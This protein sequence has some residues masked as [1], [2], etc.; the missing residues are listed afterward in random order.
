MASSRR[1][2][3][4]SKRKP[5]GS[6]KA[7]P[8]PTVDFSMSIS[9]VS[10]EPTPI[11]ESSLSSSYQ[12]H[13]LRRHH[14][15]R[16]SRHHG[17]S[18]RGGLR[19]DSP[20]TPRRPV[21][22]VPELF[23]TF[24]HV[25]LAVDVPVS[26]AAA[27][28]AAQASSGQLSRESLAA[29]QLPTIAN[30]I[31]GIGAALTA[32]KTF[33]RRQ[34]LKNVTGAFTP[35]SMTLLLGRSGSGKSVL[36][37]LLGGRLNVTSKS[38]T[39]DGEVSYNG[40]SRDELKA[41][42]PQCVSFVPQQDTHLPVMTVKETLDFAFE[43]CA[44]NPDAKPVGAVYK[45][46]ASEYPLAL[47]AT[48]LGGE[49]DPVTVTRELGLTRCQGTIVGDERIR[50]VS[51]GEKKRVTTGEMAFGPHAVSLM[52]EITT[53]LD[54]SAAFDIVNAQRRLARQQRQTVVISLQ[55]PAPEVLALFDNVLLLA[56]GEVLYH[57]PR[58]HVQTYFEALGF[59]CPPGRDLADF[60]CDLASPQQIQYEKSHAPMPGRRR[61]PRSANEFADLWIMSPMYE[62][63]VEEL[64]HLDND[65]EAYSQTHSRN[66][67]RGLFFDQEALLRVPA[68]RQSYLRSTWTVVKR[69]MRLFARNKVF[70][71][72]RLLLDLLVGLMVGS[73]Y[74]GIDLADSQV[75]LGVIFSCALFLGLGQS[76]T[77]AP[78]FDAREVFYKHRGANFYRT[79]SYVLATCLSQIP[80]AITE[81]LVFGSL[82]YWMGGFIA[83]A[84][85]FVVF[86]LYML[87]TVLVFVG[88][89]FFLSTACST[90]HVA[91]PASTLALLFFILFAGFAVSREQLP[92][93][94][95]WIY[96]SNPLA[97]TTRGVMVSQYRS[98][99]LDVCEYGGIDYC[100][101][102]GGQTLG[103]YSLGLYDVPDDPKWVV[104]GIVFLASM[105]VVSMF[106]SF[107]MLE[108]HCH[109]SSS[110]LPPSLP[111]SF[112]NTAI[113]TPRQPKESYAMLSTPHGDADELL[114]SDI[115]GFPGDRNGIAVL[116]GDDDINESF[117]AS[118]GLRTNTEEIM[119][120][121][122]PRWD[123]PPV[124]LAFQD[125]RYS[126]TV[127]ADAVADPAGAP[128]RPV[129]VDSRDNAGKTKET[130]TRELLKGVTG[131]AVPGTMTALMG[132]TGA[133]KTT[134]MDVL[135]GRKS[136]K[137]GSNKKKKNGAPTLRGRVLLNG[138]DATELAVR[139]CTGYCEQ[140]DVHSDA[141][142]FREAL[143]FS[144]YLRQ[145]DR[146]APERVEEIVD[147][148]LDLLGLS[149]VAG[150][151][152]RGSSS[153]QLKR[154]TL[155]VELA[156]QPS[157]LFLDEPT[158]GLDAR[159]AKALMDGVRKVADS[160]RT[161]ICT[162]HQPSTEVFLLFDTL[163]LLQR[164]GET[165]Y[166][167]ELGRNCETLVNYFQGLGLPR[168]TPAF[169]PGDNPA[170]WMLD[171]I[172]AA[173]KN[174]RLQHLDASLNSSVSSEY[175]RQ[176]RDE[177]FDFV[178]AYRSSRLKQRLDAKRAVP[179]VFMPSDRL[180]PVT[181]AQRRAASD[182]LQFTM[183]MR[184]FLRLYWRS[185]FYTFTRM[186]TALT[187]GLMFG[188]VYSGSNDFTSYQGAN[189]AVGLI[190]F[191]TCFLGVGAY[192]HVLPV[193]FEERGP[194]YRERASE[195][196]SALWYFVASSVVEIPYA[197]VASMIFV[198]VFYPMA[199]FSAYGDF[200]QV[201]V[202]WLV[203]TMH[204]LFQTF[205]G[206]FFT[207]AMPSIELAAVWGALFDSIFL[208]FMG[209]NPP[210]ASIPD[211]YKWL[212][213]LVP[214]R[215][216]FEVLTALVLGDCPDEQLRQIADAS[217]TNTTIDVSD[218][219]LG[220]QPLTEAPPAVAN[221]S[222]TSY[223]DQVF[224]ARREDT[225]RSVAVVVGLIL[226]MR[227]ATLI[228]MRVVNHQKR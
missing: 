170:T 190:F 188:L 224:A 111:A 124:T 54:S 129:A 146:V 14:Q 121:L 159:A 196:Y 44:I 140:T 1:N 58:A 127:P 31:R 22:A 97:W 219:P 94:L 148:C 102:Y 81:T 17:A 16:G 32:N 199:G 137:P 167:G 93:A 5:S 191:S 41:Q 64:D 198:S 21:G 139:R 40:L 27:A 92:S 201:V 203:L 158:S 29:K 211:G 19:D 75:T 206:Q 88:E 120:R 179:G 66:G 65:T 20:F 70:F 89:Y 51:G 118:Q 61:H 202:Y 184:R 83:T 6:H 43:C 207:F 214:H 204:I 86:V 39:L 25:S 171:V 187:L 50:G 220:C 181:F 2:A 8:L 180:P 125:L 30:H 100:K 161:V 123:V 63:M 62:A 157:V 225:T 193:A 114:E 28:A 217:A 122:T 162:I 155:G 182:G 117:F 185:P 169:K 143:Q 153:E 99:E 90:L 178:A 23:V 145:G 42:L 216:T 128:G 215:Y 105:Y 154:L 71:V 80:L 33:V 147:E 85:Q 103:E 37:K 48:Y 149:D 53:G 13:V 126:I 69:Q 26:P 7:K 96:W 176:H 24:R 108:Y 165:V 76:A 119:V 107:V 38:V 151:L 18:A 36:L 131:Y 106:L 228:V 177:A 138:V 74:Y 113:P 213:Q 183:L 195:T 133:G 110:V 3:R 59:V 109:E 15:T 112:S 152:I 164:G 173:T 134:L 132:S 218:W 56:D 45:S 166:F 91:Q 67:E 212:F 68:F 141:S 142:T 221:I 209:Y 205:F 194:Y 222:L 200:A 49:R 46:P 144:A 34:I 130:V 101:T 95:R 192:I 72:G 98:S 4:N 57:G 116:G 78:F 197:A 150:Q 208:M 84:E 168:N 52:D 210:A 73:V 189:G 11:L 115:T 10:S 223:I 55:Q 77:L 87:L 156:A 82:V 104:L 163:L 9:S 136:G 12:K 60:L 160:G 172:G 47:P 135:A 226:L 186:V 79:S 35:G 175:S 227:L 174:P